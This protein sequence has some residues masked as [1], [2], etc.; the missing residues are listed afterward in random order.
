MD[1]IDKGMLCN[2]LAKQC[3]F[4]LGVCVMRNQMLIGKY[5]Y[6]TYYI[7]YIIYYILYIIYPP[8][9]QGVTACG[10]EGTS[11]LVCSGESEGLE[12]P[13]PV[14]LMFVGSSTS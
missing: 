9:R 11:Q 14:F 2:M 6:L 12:P 10:S 7:L 5:I 3:I 1:L 13:E 8:T 4:V